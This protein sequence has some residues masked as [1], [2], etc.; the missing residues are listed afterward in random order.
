MLL[1]LPSHRVSLP[2]SSDTFVKS[3]IAPMIQCIDIDTL[4][5]NIGRHGI[6]LG[7]MCQT[8]IGRL[9]I[10]EN[11]FNSSNLMSGIS[12]LL[13]N[14]E[15]NVYKTLFLYIRNYLFLFKCLRF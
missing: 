6:R 9:L 1:K 15:N 2:S 10:A 11:I 12:K 3:F 8:G 4:I 13:A 7:S 5:P 14:L